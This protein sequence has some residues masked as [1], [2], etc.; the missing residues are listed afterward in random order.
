MAFYPCRFISQG[1]ECRD[2]MSL[3]LL[4]ELTVFPLFV[5]KGRSGEDEGDIFFDERP[6]RQAVNAPRSVIDTIP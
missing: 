1:A 3:A 2:G 5:I 4:Q 6:F